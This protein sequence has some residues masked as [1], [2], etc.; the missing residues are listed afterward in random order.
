MLIFFLMLKTRNVFGSIS[1]LFN[2]DLYEALCARILFVGVVLH[3]AR[4]GP[5]LRKEND[6]SADAAGWT[7]LS[8]CSHAL[9]KPGGPA[10]GWLF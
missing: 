1:C 7:P 3:Y 2:E 8:E 9:C 10:K 4:F 6:P 5:P